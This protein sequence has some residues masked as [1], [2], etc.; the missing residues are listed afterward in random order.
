MI[1]WWFSIVF[2]MFTRPGNPQPVLGNITPERIIKRGWPEPFSFSCGDPA[3]WLSPIVGYH[4]S[5]GSKF[6]KTLSKPQLVGGWPTPLKNMSSSVGMMTFPTEWKVIK[7]MFQSPP[8][9]QVW[10]VI[11]INHV[12]T[13]DWDTQFW[14]IQWVNLWHLPAH[15]TRKCFR[16]LVGYAWGSPR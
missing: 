4:G 8:T 11:G 15:W 14:P 7:D 12:S 13:T 6:I 5:H 10:C 1:A 3:L 16:C 2:C 9:W